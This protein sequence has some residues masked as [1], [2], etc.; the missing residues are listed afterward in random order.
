M[1]RA[2]WEAYTGLPLPARKLILSSLSAANGEG[3][4]GST[5]TASTPP[6]ILSLGGLTQTNGAETFLS[7]EGTQVVF[8]Q[9]RTNKT[10][11]PKAEGPSFKEDRA[12]QEQVIRAVFT[13][14][15]AL[16]KGDVA[17]RL[18]VQRES[19]GGFAMVSGFDT[20]L[21]Y[22]ETHRDQFATLADF[23]P[24]LLEGIPAKTAATG[25]EVKTTPAQCSV[26]VAAAIPQSSSL[27]TNGQ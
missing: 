3:K 25:L 4:C 21:R 14:I 17:G 6:S 13:R 9:P 11:K 27:P 1:T 10:I 20:R 18:A 15:T 2:Y 12:V 23:L 16:A 19:V 24:R 7:T 8:T 26:Q 5:S 22:Y